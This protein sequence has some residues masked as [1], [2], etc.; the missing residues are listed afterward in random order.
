VTGDT[1]DGPE[2][3]TRTDIR[4]RGCKHLDTEKSYGSNDYEEVYYVCAAKG[5]Q[6]LPMGGDHTPE[7]CPFWPTGY[8][9][10]GSTTKVLRVPD[11]SEQWGGGPRPMGWDPQAHE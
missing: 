9:R 7:W 10:D 5:R 2:V 3:E 8:T 6:A 11:R 1:R 4:C